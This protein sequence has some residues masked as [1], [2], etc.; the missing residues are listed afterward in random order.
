MAHAVTSQVRLEA[1]LRDRYVLER[2][3]GRGGMATVF[4]ARDLRHD[5]L[6]ALKVLDMG[7]QRGRL[8]A[9]LCLDQS[10]VRS[11][12]LGIERHGVLRSVPS[13]RPRGK[14]VI[15]RTQPAR[16]SGVRLSTRPGN[17]LP[18]FYRINPG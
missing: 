2:E 15:G 16:G 4:L 14:A 17:P 10:G 5:R 6:V 1:A 3:L 11:R 12:E 8:A 13:F 9:D 7:D 18:G